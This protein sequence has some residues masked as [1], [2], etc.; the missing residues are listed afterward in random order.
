M[1]KPVHYSDLSKE[2]RTSDDVL[3]WREPRVETV[4]ADR[5]LTVEDANGIFVSGAADLVF[6]LPATVDGLTFTFY[7]ET[8]SA[9][10]GVSISPVA[11]DQ[12]KGTGITAADDKDLI[13]T[14]A[15]D[16]VGDLVTIVG[17][18][19]AGWIITNIIGTWAR[20]A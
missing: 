8:L 20:E 2:F 17:D 1:G 6:T 5:T 19:S 15:T 10:T 13:N 9:T 7:T 11:A 12:I 18:G 3:V 4:S 16:A 14:A